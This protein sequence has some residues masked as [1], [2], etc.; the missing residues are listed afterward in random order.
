MSGLS[1]LLVNVVVVTTIMIGV[2]SSIRANQIE[3]PAI[4]RIV[5]RIVNR[6]AV[7]FTDSSSIFFLHLLKHK[8]QYQKLDRIPTTTAAPVTRACICV[9]FYLCDSNQTIITD[10]SGII[11]IRA[12]AEQCTGPFE[13]CCYPPNGTVPTM[14]PTIPTV[15]FPTV[16]PTIPTITFP[17]VSPTTA[18]PSPSPTPTGLPYCICVDISLC[19]PNGIVTISG[20][21]VIDPR[22]GLCPGTQVCCRILA[23]TT[24][25]PTVPTITFPTV[26][27]TTAPPSPSPTPT[28]LPYCICVD[29]SLCDPNGIVTISGEGVIDPRYGL[30]PGTQVCCRIL[31]NTT[32]PPT[33]PTITFPTVSPT[34][35][36]P[37]PSPTPTGLPYCICVDISLCDPN[38]I[39]NISGEGVINPRYG[40]CPDTQVCCRILA[41]TT[42]P[43][44][45]P[46]I[47]FPTV[48]PTTAPP[49]PSPTPT[50]LPYCI[51]VDISLCDPNGIV[52]ISGEGVIN[53]RYGLCPDTQ[54]CCR[55]LANT[56]LPPT[57]PP[58]TMTTMPPT[59]ET[60]GQTQLCFVCGNI[61]ICFTCMIVISP[62]GGGMIDPRVSQ[63]LT[64]GSICSMTN[65]PSCQNVKMSNQIRTMDLGPVKNPGTSQECYCVK[66]WLCS[67]GNAISPD[68][69]GIIDSR[70]TVCSS[71][72]QVCCR[73]VGINL[74]SFRAS[75]SGN[76]FTKRT[77][78]GSS[79]RVTCGI[80]NN[81]YAPRKYKLF[82]STK[83]SQPYPPDS[84]K[85][86]F[87][88]FPW[89]VALLLKSSNPY[90]FHC[91]ASLISSGAIL[92]A[93]HCV[94]NQRPE[95]LIARFGQ[96]NL[97]SNVQPLPIQ[98]VNILA[99][100]I[101]P[102]FYHDGLFHDVAVLVLEKPVIYGANILP[103]CLPEQGMV[104]LAGT[105][106]YGI[107]WGSDSFGPEGKYQAEL[108]RVNLPIIDR[109]DC[110]TRLRN[111]K[112]GQYFQLHG[113]FICAGGVANKDT[114]RGDG[115][116][117]LV[118][119]ASTGQYF[120]AGIVSWGIGCGDN[121]PAVYA[122]V[123]QHRQWIDQQFATYGV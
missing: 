42:L 110:Q 59:T 89:M 55:I 22:Y 56:T 9:P 114:C 123:S 95:N 119:Q 21:G 49:S 75:S 46:T 28:G 2:A 40:L 19:D 100:A 73:L 66:S 86:Y 69:L 93:A 71:T 13:V 31:A 109:D 65:L 107:G 58:T 74:Q 3:R 30:C 79:S 115:G 81:N 121:V 15:T 17:T 29:I 85:T 116:G 39:V 91:G 87:A 36:P 101:H 48:S 24:L 32:L 7:P 97:G 25:P 34:T 88:E 50:G 80:Q 113:S 6:D 76:S 38:G 20:E 106:C 23:N 33:V 83:F 118:C 54:V 63:V 52:N 68:G 5:N 27:P 120:Q 60:P 51:C 92:T 67:E 14:P 57:N 103:I 84:E 35:A 45:V 117:P 43:P 112:L 96:W 82:Y 111:T 102:S 104:F 44:T 62:G 105:S 4:S 26:S 12:G 10:G 108:R 53:P 98:E 37:S 16:S 72:D 78:D 47:T 99:I 90:V 94:E 77:S 41:N 11:D 70:F 18:P 1:V 61:T 64:D 122:S 8:P